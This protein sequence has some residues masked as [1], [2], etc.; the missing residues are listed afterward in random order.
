[1]T[2]IRVLQVFTTMGRGGAESMIMNYYRNIDRT[3]VQ[4]DFLVHRQERAAFDDEIE[5]MG[6][7]IYR[8]PAINPINPK[9]YY[10][11]LRTFFKTHNTYRIVHSHLNTFSTFTLKIAEEFKIPTRIAHAH[12]AMDP[13]TLKNT[14]KSIPNT[15]EA[16]KKVVKLL[17]IC[18]EI[19]S[20]TKHPQI[21]QLHLTN[22]IVEQVN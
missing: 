7:V 5:Q 1:M 8:M 9:K 11:T 15:I 4:F 3:K 13:I 6:G 16:L 10:K 14:L 19:E 12:I 22:A 20:R 21:N 2:P 17:C 18:E